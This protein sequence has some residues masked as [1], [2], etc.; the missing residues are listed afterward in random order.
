MFLFFVTSVAA[1]GTSLSDDT[2]YVKFTKLT[3]DAVPGMVCNLQLGVSPANE[4]RGLHFKC[5]GRS[6]GYYTV[7]QL[8]KGVVIYH[9]DPLDLD[10]AT[11]SAP[12]LDAVHGGPVKVTYVSNFLKREFQAWD[13]SIEVMG[14]NWV[15]YT[16]R[17]QGHQPFNDLFCV[18]RTVLGQ[19]VGIKE[20]QAKWVR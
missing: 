8:R 18:K 7:E 10:V 13:G 4:L 5:E 11:I 15:G 14:T 16:S 20:I 2:V 12:G 6:E 19:T 9:Y 3:S 1:A 17:A